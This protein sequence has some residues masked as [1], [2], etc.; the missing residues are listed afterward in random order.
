MFSPDRQGL[1]IALRRVWIGTS[2]GL[3]KFAQPEFPV[4]ELLPP[5][6]LTSVAGSSRQWQPGDDP[7]LAYSSRSLSIQ[8]AALAYE[9]GSAIRF[10]YRLAGFDQN[11]TETNERG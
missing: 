6:V 11:W 8:Y 5:V 1:V 7:T 3:S 9:F 2:G 4:E 10:R